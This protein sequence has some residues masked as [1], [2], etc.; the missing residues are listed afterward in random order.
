[1]G[2]QATTARAIPNPVKM[3]FACMFFYSFDLTQT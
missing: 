3:D 1:V 2:S